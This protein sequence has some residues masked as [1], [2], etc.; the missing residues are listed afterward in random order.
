MQISL[1]PAR[2]ACK[3]IIARATAN[4]E[5]VNDFVLQEPV[6]PLGVVVGVAARALHVLHPE[7]VEVRAV[8]QVLF[9]LCV[10]PHLGHRRRVG[11]NQ[12]VGVQKLHELGGV[13]HRVVDAPVANGDAPE[14]EARRV[15]LIVVQNGVRPRGDVVPTV[16]LAADDHFVGGV[17]R[18]ELQPSIEKG[19][20]VFPRLNAAGALVHTEAVPNAHG[21]VHVKHVA[22]LVPRVSIV[23]ELP[24]CQLI[25]FLDPVQH[26]GPVLCG[27]SFH[28]CAAGPSI[29]PHNQ[30]DVFGRS[31][32]SRCS[33]VHLEKPAIGILER[34]VINPHHP[35]I[36]VRSPIRSVRNTNPRPRQ[37][38]PTPILE[39]DTKHTFTHQ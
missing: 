35:C 29:G 39:I 14:V 19:H 2:R 20:D 23:G 9:H 10:G 7:V 8:A 37:Q 32:R 15:V 17:L 24:R 18:K 22:L 16:R 31:K 27:G 26:Q 5:G 13:L 4:V 30:R 36:L 21:L 25:A 28:G 11:R 12:I 1:S 34:A 38:S 6:R 3:G 33:S